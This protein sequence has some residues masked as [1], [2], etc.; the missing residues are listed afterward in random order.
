MVIYIWQSKTW[1]QFT[2]SDSEILKPL[3]MARKNQGQI[4]GQ[5]KFLELK[6]Q[7]EILVNETLA[8]SAIEGE[9]LDRNNVRSSVAKR[10]G[11][12]SAGLPE[13]ARSTDGLVEMLIDATTNYKIKLNEKQLWGW[14]AALFPT[15]Y[16]GIQKIEVG[17]WRTGV[18]PMQ[19]ISGKMG[20]PKIHYEAPD[21]EKVVKEMQKFFEWWNGSQELDGILR[22]AL[23]HFWFVTIHPFE[24]GNGRLAR[25]LTDM[26]LAQ[27]ENT[28]MR[29][30]SLSSQIVKE[31]DAYYLV[32]EE[33]QKGS[34][35]ITKWLVWFF[36]MF[37]RALEASAS[38]IEKSLLINKFFTSHDSSNLNERQ[39]K[40]LRKLFETWPDD[41]VGGLTT[42]KYVSMTKSSPATAKRD[43]E[44]LIE[45]KVLIANQGK[46]RS[47]SYRLND[48]LISKG[49]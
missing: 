19:V 14:R 33:T 28:K 32:L 48:T 24:D 22:A 25:A 38:L 26:A 44:E 36:E 47:S 16:S 3:A 20:K 46:G 6:E 12:P 18:E 27:D 30:Y 4:L 13:S 37:S 10:L 43:I 5:A 23:A 7:A 49:E 8:T 2:W 15:G 45:K 17:Q 31:R 29:L 39:K 40:V 9:K 1:P 21:S 34:G 11:L 35:D 42:K 41:F